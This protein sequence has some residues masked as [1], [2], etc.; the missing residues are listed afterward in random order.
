MFE[1][2]W[3]QEFG[4]DCLTCGFQRSL[5][6]LFKGEF[7]ESFLMFPATI[8]FLL[9]VLI[10]GLYIWKRFNNGHKW[11]ISMFGLTSLLIVVNYSVK[12]ANGSLMH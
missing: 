12:I 6:L 2:S 1:C 8:P 3:R 9:T 10:A 7:V 11:I 4:V 5:S